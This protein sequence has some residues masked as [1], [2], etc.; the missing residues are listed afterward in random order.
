[1]CAIVFFLSR[2]PFGGGG[3]EETLSVANMDFPTKSRFYV[4]V[5]LGIF[6]CPVASGKFG[7]FE[8]FVVSF[9]RFCINEL[10][11]YFTLAFL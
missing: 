3:R 2:C 9:H 1:M 4:F 5:M 8:Y 11:L 7:G 6:I 10:F